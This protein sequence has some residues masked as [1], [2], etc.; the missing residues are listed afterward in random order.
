[1]DF[2]LRVDSGKKVIEPLVC[3]EVLYESFEQ[4]RCSKLSFDI[5]A[6]SQSAVTEGDIV[7]L[8]VGGSGVFLGV[9]F[10][11]RQSGGVV[12]V[13]A[14]DSL[15]YLKNRDT[16][17]YEKQ[18]A[19]DIVRRIAMDYNLRLGEIAQTKYVIASRVE[20]NVSL[21]EMIANALD[22]ELSQTGRRYVLYDEF[23]ALRLAE[24]SRMKSKAVIDATNSGTVS[25]ASS[26]DNRSNRIK[27]ARYDKKAGKREIGVASDSA[28]EK[29][30][31]VLQHYVRVGA[32]SDVKLTEHA[33]ALLKL[34]NK[35]DTAISVGGIVGDVRVRGGVSVT[36]DLPV[37]SGEAHVTRCLHRL[38]PERHL[39]DVV[40]RI[41]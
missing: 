30:I 25:F 1:M 36:V 28:S 18:R 3:G 24:Q 33:N 32:R 23:G 21:A 38:L 14:Y 19:S 7:S 16:Y 15:R 34:Q 11:R 27:V 39:M 37:F 29:R 20:D 31:G 5:L 9:V 40:L 6:D 8:R 26:V 2:E 17:V 35:N 12:S 13:Y 22:I 4:G 41:G 10:G